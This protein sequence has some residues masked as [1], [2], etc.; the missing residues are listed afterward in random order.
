MNCNY[1]KHTA[2]GGKFE[3]LSVIAK[4]V[5][6]E[7]TSG[8]LLLL[9]AVAAMFVANSP[10]GDY[11]FHALHQPVGI[12]IGKDS[13]TLDV[14]HWI[15]DAL[16]ALFFLMVGLE[17]KREFLIGELSGFQK[18]AFP[19]FAAIG[20]MVIPALVFYFITV[21][22]GFEGGFGIPMATDIAFALGVLLMLGNRVSLSVKVFL[23]SLAVVDDI[24]AI[25]VIAIFYSKGVDF[26][27]LF[28]AFLVMVILGAL[29]FFNVNR[30]FIYLFFGAVLW[31]FVLLSGI[32]ATIAGVLLAFFIPL[33]SKISPQIFV[34]R[35]YEDMQCFL[36]SN[37][38]KP[39]LSHNQLNCLESMA[40]MYDKVQNPLVRL[41]H[42]LHPISAYF[43]MPLFA[44]ANAGV[45]IS[46]ESFD[47]T[48]LVFVGVFLGL[49]LGKPL[50]I[51]SF[52]YLG[53]KAG[54]IR[55]PE[56][57]SWREIF[58]VGVLAG[59][60]FT[61]SIFISNLA[62]V[63]QSIIDLAKL[64]IVGASVIAIIIGYGFFATSKP[65]TTSQ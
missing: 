44:F 1:S 57:L 62:F 51:V 61:M 63:D 12:A 40:D 30:L 26:Y 49:L 27:W 28:Q 10:L 34:S 22:S 19:V 6:H 65:K 37:N 55:K 5:K 20:G 59:I 2:H 46:A 4:Y 7:S 14:L 21:G 25:I 31:T 52:T 50:G 36:K 23:V 41:E 38:D 17:I 16:M 42:N 9:S 48:H 53:S 29:N 32:H 13:I 47:V 64:S 60:G 8:I 39:I 3:L 43:I 56:H 35:V 45:A 15:N 54:I 18:A 24:G 11:Y 33:R 58:G